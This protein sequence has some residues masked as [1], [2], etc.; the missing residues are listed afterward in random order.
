MKH[1]DDEHENKLT[2]N[3]P[4]TAGAQHLLSIQNIYK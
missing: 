2:W 3:I 4:N 1:K